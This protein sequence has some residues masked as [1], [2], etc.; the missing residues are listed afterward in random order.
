LYPV[1]SGAWERGMPASCD[2]MAL[3]GLGFQVCCLCAC[4]P[5]LSQGTE[6]LVG[7]S[8]RLLQPCR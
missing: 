1:P 2:G 7:L 6:G 5:G 8:S 3:F 4:L